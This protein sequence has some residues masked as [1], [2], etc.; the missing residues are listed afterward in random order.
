MNTPKKKH[1][2]FYGYV[3]A[4]ACFITWFIGWGAYAFSFGV[5]FKPLLQ[6]FHWSRAETSLAY[7]IS[8]LIQA[9]LGVVMGW[10]TD[11][12]GPR[13]VVTVFGSFLGWS[14]LLVSQAASLWQ[15]I[16]FYA[17]VGGIGASTLNIPIM[18]TVTRWFVKRRGLMTGIVQ[19]GAGVGGFFFAPFAGWLILS[20]GWRSASIILGVLTTV[21]MIS[22]GLFLVRDPRDIGQFPDGLRPD[23]GEKAG[24]PVKGYQSS[25]SFFRSIFGTAPFWMLTVIYASFGYYRS[26]FTAHIAAHVQDVGFTL[27]DGANVLALIS[28]GTIFGRLGMGRLGDMIGTRRTLIMSFMV[29][30]LIIVWLTMSTQ[31]WE[32]Y[33][34][35]VFYGFGWGAVAVLRFAV[36]AEIFGL[37][38]VGL[39]MGLLGFSESLAATF[40]SYFGGLLFDRSGNYDMA[41]ILCIAVCVLGILMSWRLK[42]DLLKNATNI[43]CRE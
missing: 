34:F 27:S 37:G 40:S 16:I 18:A 10:L 24:S 6:E 3:V 17:V 35:G 13:I 2:I 25:R 30:G 5:F 9:G 33:L 7:A 4:A 32:L 28:F 14:F 22:A 23:P 15:F 19:T 26:T 31:L 21:L 20:Y 36:T 29:T 11:K 38:S 39:I 12:L 1:R 42:P 43:G 8:F 41:F